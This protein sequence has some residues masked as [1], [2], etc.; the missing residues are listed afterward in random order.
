MK[1]QTIIHPPNTTHQSSL[2]RLDWRFLLPAP[3]NG[4]FRHLL[5]CGGNAALAQQI[6]TANLADQVSCEVDT[7][8]TRY[9]AAVLLHNSP[10]TVTNIAPS[11][12][13]GAVFYHELHRP[14]TATLQ[15]SPTKLRRRF[16]QVGMT[17]TGI[18][19]AAPNFDQCRRYIPLDVPDALQW[20]FSSV[21]VAGSPLLRLTR[22]LFRLS[23]RGKH[24]P[25]GLLA[26]CICLT[27][28]VGVEATTPASVLSDPHLR[29]I[30][31]TADL[32]P[33]LM[34][35][36]QDDASR[37]I[38][39]PFARHQTA[40]PAAVIKIATDPKFNGETENEQTVLH[41]VRAQVD[42][43]TRQSIPV[44]LASFQYQGLAVGVESRAAGHSLWL[45]S[46]GWGIPQQ[47]KLND[48]Q[49][50]TRWL[51]HF[52]RQTQSSRLTWD[53]RAIIRWVEE[54]LAAYAQWRTLS[55]IEEQGFS[56]L[57]EYAHTLLGLELPLVWQHHDFAPWN[58]FGHGDQLTVIDW[59][60]NR[61]WDETRE[62]P[63]LC[64]LLYFITYWNNLTARLYTDEAELQGL[65]HLFIAN[66]E[67]SRTLQA[68]RNA[69][70]EYMDALAMNPRFLPLLL[71]YTWIERVVYSHS[72]TQK[73]RGDGSTSRAADKFA[74]YVGLLATHADALFSVNGSGFWLA[75]RQHT[76]RSNGDAS[77]RVEP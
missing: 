64:D 9:D 47:R 11:L 36:G 68:A 18:Y 55:P 71:L 52:H 44:P 4:S 72:R 20:Y 19:W 30:L 10:L 17:L 40:S 62:G 38:L 75:H 48:L 54:P 35:S 33:M 58:L 22:A 63:A 67:S 59:E 57:R 65:Y 2:R 77:E 34:T 45:S 13:P 1:S 70:A 56:R 32:R 26:P 61:A 23:T 74:K 8:D 49:L 60:F 73:L 37:V 29:A 3:P 14:L 43:A 41:E 42:E 27:A 25:L 12:E 69:I 15:L 50:G 39:L 28:V 66:M 21:F 7:T 46:G 76:S 5:L 31:P 6:V 16:E 24:H 51:I 53:H